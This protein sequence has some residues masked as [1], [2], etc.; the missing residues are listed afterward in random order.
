MSVCEVIVVNTTD[1][2]VIHSKEELLSGE[3]TFDNKQKV[4]QPEEVC[5]FVATTG[6]ESYVY[7][8]KLERLHSIKYRAPGEPH[9]VVVLH[10]HKNGGEIMCDEYF[11]FECGASM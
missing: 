9:I 3:Y 5:K 6:S 8:P 4:I 7:N 2:I 11:L 1:T 10:D